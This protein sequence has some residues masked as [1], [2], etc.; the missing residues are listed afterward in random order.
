MVAAGAVGFSDDG[1]PVSDPMV[2]RR[3]ARVL[4]GVRRAG[5]IAHCEVTELV[6]GI[7]NEG[8]VS[9]RLGLKSMPDVRR[10]GEAARDILLAELI[11][12]R[13]HIAHVSAQVDGR[14]CPLGQGARGRR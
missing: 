12:G 1:S 10:V 8:R 4:Q 5:D 2:M 9:T 14:T 6:E 7:A 3:G 13:L 11:G